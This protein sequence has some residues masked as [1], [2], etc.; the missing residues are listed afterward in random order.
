M[1]TTAAP[2]ASN[3]NKNATAANNAAAQSVRNLI[4]FSFTPETVA[5]GVLFNITAEKRTHNGPIMSGSVEV[6]N[7]QIPVS[8]FLKIAQESGKE[9]LALSIGQENGV[10]YYGKLFRAEGKKKFQ[11]APDYNGFITL[12]PCSE[13]QQYTNEEWDAAPTLKITAYRRRN[14]NSTARIAMNIM[15]LSV[16]ASDLNF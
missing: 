1:T 9:Y 15:P 13:A 6:D 11:T 2:K 4:A 5:N 8:G 7:V 14:A 10:H 16:K 12:L 3:K